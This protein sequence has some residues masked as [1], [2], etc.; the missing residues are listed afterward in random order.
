MMADG[1][2]PRMTAEEIEARL[3]QRRAEAEGGGG[4]PGEPFP[5]PIPA[6]QLRLAEA[7]VSWIWNG[8]LRRG[9]ITLMPALWKAG[10]TTLLAYL[11][12]ALGDG[13]DFLGRT[14]SPSRV[15][16]VAEESE[17]RWAERRDQVGIRDHV[18]FVIRPF[19]AKPSVPRWQDFL[20]YVGGLVGQGGYDV[21][22]FDTLA[23]LWPLK[24]ENDAAS[25]QAC[26][27]PLHGMI[28]DRVALHLVHHTRKSDGMEATASRGSGALTGFVDTI[29]EFRRFMPQ[30]R[31]D[32]RRVI[33][34]YG[35][36]EET[37]Q[38]LVIELT[39]HGYVARGDRDAVVKRDLSGVILRVL[40]RGGPGLTVDQLLEQ[41]P[42]DGGGK[43]GRERLTA[44]LKD[45]AEA[46]RWVQ[47]GEGK[48]GK[49]W[50][51]YAP[52]DGA[53]GRPE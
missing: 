26:L 4:S 47:E 42:D 13:D 20:S 23:N 9:E 38:E 8:F 17:H 44:T 52:F 33:S 32:R 12:R 45:G 6:S 49:P 50:L 28:G 21:V 15:L 19:P 29:V 34:G 36:H 30:D 46:G 37:P 39:E 5:R 10:K 1:D 41:W 18:D 24:D 31:Q 53:E 16:Y 48:R 14:V 27:M 2:D 51:F 43:P 40:P 25:V 3:R 11:L 35:R 7:G 22:V